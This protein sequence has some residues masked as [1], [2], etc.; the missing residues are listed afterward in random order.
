MKKFYLIA[1]FVVLFLVNAFSQNELKNALSLE[2]GYGG[3]DGIFPTYVYGLHYTKSFSSRIDAYVLY[4]VS[5]G[6]DERWGES[7]TGK[8]ISEKNTAESA[9]TRF[10]QFVSMGLGLKI[11]V[12]KT[13]KSYLYFVLGSRLMKSKR[14][15][16]TGIGYEDGENYLSDIENYAESK[17]G[18]EIG[19]G[20][21]REFKE[22][23]FAGGSINHIQVGG[24]I[25]ASF[26]IGI[27]F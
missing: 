18:Y 16:I 5:K 8:Y 23:Y 10:Y 20:Y 13:E 2:L 14:S 4:N 7:L 21:N 25:S 1:S 12:V 6:A 24:R 3:G 19:I 17:V 15:S 27:M 11:R 22:K 26:H 9:D